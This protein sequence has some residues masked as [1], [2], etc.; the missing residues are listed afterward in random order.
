MKAFIVE[1]PGDVDALQ[2]TELPIPESKAGKVIVKIKAFGLNRTET[3]TRR[4]MAPGTTY[5]IVPGIEAVGII[6]DPSDST[7]VKGQKVAVIHPHHMGF[8]YHGSYAEYVQVPIKTV[9]PV[10]TQLDW[11]TFGAL[12]E[13][14]QVVWGALN[15]SLEIKKGEVLLIRGGT[16]SVGMTA[17]RLAKKAGLT[18]ISTTRSESKTQGMLDNGVDHVLIDKGEIADEVR[19]LY[20]EGIDKVLE[21]IGPKTVPDSL[22]CVKKG[23]IVAQVGMVGESPF[24][25]NFNPF[26]YIPSAVKLTV[27]AGDTEDMNL[28]KFQEYVSDIENGRE[29]VNI[30]K[31]FHFDEVPAAHKMMDEN[32]ASGKL[33]VLIEN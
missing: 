15:T 9:F 28:E 8:S 6:E 29:K 7:F 21:I 32:K 10:D 14:F 18:V 27:Y 19:K 5:P 25:E 31:V 12:P 11:A 30:S 20:P 17:A 2:L 33:V 24:I 13:M 3:F 22:K 26:A 16:S 1:N 23:G 4:G